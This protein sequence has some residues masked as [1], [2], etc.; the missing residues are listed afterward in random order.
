MATNDAPARVVDTALLKNREFMSS[1][2]DTNE[3]MT[4]QLDF[5]D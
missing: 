3:I 5:Q 2:E 4:K 1:M